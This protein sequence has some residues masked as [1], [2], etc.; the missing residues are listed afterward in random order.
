MFYFVNNIFILKLIHFI[1][2]IIT[3]MRK[4]RFKPICYKQN[5]RDGTFKIVYYHINI[6]QFKNIKKNCNIFFV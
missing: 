3:F 5:L 1:Y 6:I 4:A 2:N